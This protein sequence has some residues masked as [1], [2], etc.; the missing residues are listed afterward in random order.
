MALALIKLPVHINTLRLD[1]QLWNIDYPSVYGLSNYYVQEKINQRIYTSVMKLVQV[2][3]QPDML[4]YVSMSYEIKTNERNIL[5]LVLHGLG[6]FHGAHPVSNA[7]SLTFDVATGI[8]YELR[9]L[10]IPDSGYLQK[11][12]DIVEA[13]IKERDIQLISEFKGIQPDQDYYIADK[14]LIIYFQPYEIT[15]GYYGFPYFPI[16]IYTLSDEIAEGSL[17]YRIGEIF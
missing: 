12:S 13:Q 2:L 1:N 4:T 8:C 10:F 7:I 11:I 15:P 17:L 9:D 3:T 16:P 5:S 6:D 14:A